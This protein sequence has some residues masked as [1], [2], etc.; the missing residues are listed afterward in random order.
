MTRSSDLAALPDPFSTDVSPMLGESY[1][2]IA[3]LTP[4]GPIKEEYFARAAAEGVDLTEDEDSRMD[5]IS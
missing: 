4:D 1:V 5:A 3:T 2:T